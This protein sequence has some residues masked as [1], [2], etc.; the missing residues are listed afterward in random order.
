MLEIKITVDAPE[1]SAAINNL[2]NAMA[3]TE[4]VVISAAE[5]APAVVP[6]VE[7]PAENTEPKETAAEATQEAVKTYNLDEISR[8]GTALIDEGKMPQLIELL[9]R[10]N[11][12]A[13]TQLDPSTYPAVAEELKALGAK[14]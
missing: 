8:A 3:N 14:L 7:A 2:A 1:L 6:A 11:V 12:Q 10:Y 13:L 5:P 9:K 4:P